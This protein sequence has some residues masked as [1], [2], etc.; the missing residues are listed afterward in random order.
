MVKK[1]IKKV[2]AHR[3]VKQTQQRR[4]DNH[5]QLNLILQG[6]ESRGY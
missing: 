4:L 5:K 3:Q 2:F 1:I 6:L